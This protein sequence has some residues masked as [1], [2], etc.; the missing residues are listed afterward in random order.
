MQTG[1]RLASVPPCSV[2]LPSFYTS[3]PDSLTF[4]RPGTLRLGDPTRS[5][6]AAVSPSGLNNA[7][8][9][10]TPRPCP[11]SISIGQSARSLAT[12]RLDYEQ[13]LQ[14]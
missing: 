1:S 4:L 13:Y 11:R 14:E 5:R 3:W 2:F 6:S 10:D 7:F 12:V 8:P 9:P